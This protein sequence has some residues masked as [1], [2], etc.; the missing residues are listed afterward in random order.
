[1]DEELKQL[2]DKLEKA[3]HD[4][5]QV[6]EQAGDKLDFNKVTYVSGTD[7]EKA[8][9]F[10][11]MNDECAKVMKEVDARRLVL[12]AKE[13]HEKRALLGKV[14]HPVKEGKQGQDR[15]EK[16]SLADAILKA[17][18]IEPGEERSE[19]SLKA[20]YWEKEREVPLGISLKTLMETGAG[21][22]AETLRTGRVVDK[23]ARPI[24]LIDL[25]PPGQTG[26]A[27]VVYM[28]ETTLTQNAAEAAEGA[29]YN[30]DAYALTERSETVRKIATFLP[31]TD[32]Q[33]EDVPQVRGYINNRLPLSLRRR[34]D[35]QILN[36]D[37]IAP[38]LTGI[39]NK[40]GIQTHSR[41]SVAGDKNLDALYRAARKV[42]VTGRGV[43]NGVIIHPEDW[44][45]IRLI[46]TND[47]AYIWGHPSMA[48]PE[49]VWG[50]PIAQSDLFAASGTAVVADFMFSELAE[51]RG[52][53][54]KLSDSHSDFF[55]KGKQALRADMRAAF[56]IYRAA[57]FCQVTNLG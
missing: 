47:G 11:K 54:L 42:R 40:S 13:D 32:E 37:G 53:V 25:I 1:M 49:T 21:W 7:E 33:L 52:I 55:I 44:E 17:A 41:T 9:A 28:E 46:K 36:G 20:F 38:N 12:K 57:A 24:Q 35:N 50:L 6:L 15:Q 26:Q 31:V 43:P 34:L 3:Q 56:V 45:D 39:L 23:A 16:L 2:Q 48:G 22:A 19:K 18:G 29:Q 4:M 10:R 27:A 51:R 5:G 30:E 14:T 8:A